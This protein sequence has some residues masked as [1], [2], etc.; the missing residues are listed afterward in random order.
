MR[1]VTFLICLLVCFSLSA[2]S[3]A[4]LLRKLEASELTYKIGNKEGEG[5][6][7]T[8]SE[9]PLRDIMCRRKVDGIMKTTYYSYKGDD[10]INF[11]K[12]E[13]DM[14]EGRFADARAKYEALLEPRKDDTYLMTRIGMTYEREGNNEKAI[15]FYRKAIDGNMVDF[16]AR[17]RLANLLAGNK[18]TRREGLDLI[19]ASTVINR[20]ENESDD[21]LWSL[22]KSCKAKSGRWT[23]MDKSEVSQ[24]AE[25]E[26]IVNVM[27]QNWLGYAMYQAAYQFEPGFKEEV[28]SKTPNGLIL[29]PYRGALMQLY[30]TVKDVKKPKDPFLGTLK[31]AVEMDLLEEFMLYEIILPGDSYAIFSV[32]DEQMERL[33]KYVVKAKLAVKK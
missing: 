20:M 16:V 9:E 15:A 3:T 29:T 31:R 22:G 27:D 21:L 4:E 33:V 11:L 1:V 14:A 25:G 2:Q 23:F 28:T 18:K 8:L 6:P 24:N 5:T 17:R 19:A 10:D 32:N 13:K 30:E 26:V 12:A 7:V